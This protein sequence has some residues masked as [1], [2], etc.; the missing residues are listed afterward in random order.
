[1]SSSLQE[2]LATVQSDKT[3]LEM[4][5]GGLQTELATVREEKAELANEVAKLRAELAETQNQQLS[6]KKEVSNRDSL[7][8]ELEQHRSLLA[9]VQESLQRM[10]DEK[11]AIQLEK[12][13][14]ESLVR[15]LEA[16]IVRSSSPHE[17]VRQRATTG[18]PPAKLPPLSPP[19]S[20]P[21]PPAPRSIVA[22]ISTGGD[23]SP[24]TS[25]I[26][27]ASSTRD[28]SFDTPATSVSG[29][30][31]GHP[32]AGLPA[33]PDAK[34]TA[35]VEEQQKL[36]DEQQKRVDEQQKHIEEQEA[37][38]KTLNKQL[39]HCEGDLQTHMD[40][41]NTLEASLGDAEKNRMQIFLILP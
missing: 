28:S 40:L 20:I 3:A 39:T 29:S 11:D 9:E 22:S 21:P 14:Q 6:L 16:R 41:V 24:V 27:T 13:R 7:A 19:P 34:L 26:I 25:S 31:H 37:M 4:E 33:A 15:E 2:E 36:L 12:N 18:V 10:R 8:K 35:K 38:I 17:A 1:M 5:V 30:V 23:V 32:I